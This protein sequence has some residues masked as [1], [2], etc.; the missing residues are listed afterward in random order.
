MKRINFL[1]PK[2]SLTPCAATKS[3]RYDQNKNKNFVAAIFGKIEKT[4]GLI[5]EKCQMKGLAL[6]IL[7]VKKYF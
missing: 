5:W 2:I 3:P 6:R 4:V 1:N 7:T